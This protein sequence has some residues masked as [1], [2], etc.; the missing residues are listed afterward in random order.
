MRCSVIL[1]IAL[2][3]FAA[4]W[5]RFRGPTGTGV[6]DAK[7]IPNE[8]TPDK[9]VAWRT[10]VMNGYSSPVLSDTTVYLTGWE[11]LKLYTLAI[12]RKTGKVRWQVEAPKH[13]AKEHKTVNTPVSP[14]PTT[15]GTNVYAFFDVFGLVCYDA[16]GK[17]RWRHPLGPF[18]MPYGA[19]T[20]PV[21]MEFDSA[22]AAM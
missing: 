8:V 11:G 15:D 5:P 13:L 9:N 6:A 4:D 1:F 20:S 10:P 18:T 14:S 7:N 2:S 19:G 22:G 12:D 3:G 21:L 16:D 17:E